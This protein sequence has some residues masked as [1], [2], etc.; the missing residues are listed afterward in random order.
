ML[1]LTQVIEFS[2]LSEDELAVI[3]EH[4]HIPEIVA[5][6]LGNQLLE[7][8]DGVRRFKH[9]VLDNLECATH[10]G[11]FDKASHL[12]ALYRS[13]DVNHPKSPGA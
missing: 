3:A 8:G 13:F 2:G 1:S 5:A 11:Q 9:F 4:E 6:E 12:A 10:R 7:S